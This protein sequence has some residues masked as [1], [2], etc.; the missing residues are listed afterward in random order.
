MVLWPD[1]K[2]QS[3]GLCNVKEVESDQ[4][5]GNAT[6]KRKTRAFQPLPEYGGHLFSEGCFVIQPFCLCE[7][8]LSVFYGTRLSLFKGSRIGK[9]LMLHRASRG[10]VETCGV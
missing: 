4:N 5:P 10:V 9:K 7:G 1:S 2:W 8:T 6:S 3:R